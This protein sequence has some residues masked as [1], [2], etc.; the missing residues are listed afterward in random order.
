M[1]V[2]NSNSYDHLA[3]RLQSLAEEFIEVRSRGFVPFDSGFDSFE[4]R[5]ALVADIH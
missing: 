5:R 4:R 2:R 1:D 3:D